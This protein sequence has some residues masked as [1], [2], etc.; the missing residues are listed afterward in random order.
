MFC[1]FVALGRVEC[2]CSYGENDADDCND[3]A[4]PYGSLAITARIAYRC[5]NEDD[6]KAEQPNNSRVIAIKGTYCRVCCGGCVVRCRTVHLG[7]LRFLA[8]AALYRVSAIASAT[9]SSSPAPTVRIK[10]PGRA[11]ARKASCKA[12]KSGYS[13]A[14]GIA[15]TRSSEVTP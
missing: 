3:S 6:R 1:C 5:C 2:K 12:E 8:F 13:V 9:L 14:F 15:F 4:Q 11:S 10:S 7:H